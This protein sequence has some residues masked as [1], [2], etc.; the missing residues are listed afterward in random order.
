MNQLNYHWKIIFLHLSKIWGKLELPGMTIPLLEK[1][2][3]LILE[4]R[5]LVGSKFY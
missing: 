4:L 1:L 3:S 5:I 2:E